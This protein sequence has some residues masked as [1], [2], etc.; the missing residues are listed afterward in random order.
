M[1]S[2]PINS[3]A[4]GAY[5]VFDP[6]PGNSDAQRNCVSNIRPAGLPIPTAADTIYYLLTESRQRQLSGVGL[7]DQ[8]S[9][10]ELR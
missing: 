3:R 5:L 1:S 9:R 10:V 6:K 2:T 7:K 8:R 4:L